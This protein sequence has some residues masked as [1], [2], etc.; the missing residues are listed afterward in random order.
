MVSPIATGVPWYH[1]ATNSLE[2][3]P[4]SMRMLPKAEDATPAMR[5]IG[6]IVPCTA[7]GVTN[8]IEKVLRVSSGMI[9]K[10]LSQPRIAPQNSAAVAQKEIIR[11]ARI[12]M[13]DGVCTLRAFPHDPLA[14][15]SAG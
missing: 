14:Q 6:S 15:S 4:P 9:E 7:F 10:A 13:L 2:I 3:A 8:P 1:Q 11:P 12:K 5:G